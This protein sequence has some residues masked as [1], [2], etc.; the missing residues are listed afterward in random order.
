MLEFGKNGLE[1]CYAVAVN[2]KPGWVKVKR[3]VSVD[4]TNITWPCRWLEHEPHQ[5]TIHIYKTS[6]SP[7]SHRGTLEVNNA[8]NLEPSP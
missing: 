6:S 8:R 4:I 1:E 5:A 3:V 7:T 2:V